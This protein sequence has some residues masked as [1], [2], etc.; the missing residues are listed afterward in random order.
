MD[1]RE[2]RRARRREVAQLIRTLRLRAGLTQ[3]GLA[4]RMTRLGEPTTRSQVSMWELPGETGQMP[5]TQK[6]LAILE[7]TEPDDRP[8]TAEE[9]R[10]RVLRARLS[11]LRL[12]R[13]PGED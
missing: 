8:E 4:R 12:R 5:E 1:R 6:F 9:R 3:E 13:S 10:A 11:G 7:A 2:R